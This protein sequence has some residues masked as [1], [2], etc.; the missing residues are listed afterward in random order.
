MTRMSQYE[1]IRDGK[2]LEIEDTIEIN[3]EYGWR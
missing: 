3:R 1:I 2:I